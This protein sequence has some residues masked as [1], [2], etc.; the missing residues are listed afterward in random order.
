MPQKILSPLDEFLALLF[1]VLIPAFIGV[2]I[3]IAI[4][5]KRKT[6]TI[7]RAII[8]IFTGIGLAWLCS[9]VIMKA[10]GESYQGL[11]IALVA[12]TSEK[13]MEWLLYKWNIDMFL[14]ALAEA[15]KDFAINLLT[16]KK[17]K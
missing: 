5:M 2:S 9:P 17:D 11:I 13:S 8:A 15:V 6:M 16:G 14:G 10:V 1:K 12:I 4:E 7:R 3:Q